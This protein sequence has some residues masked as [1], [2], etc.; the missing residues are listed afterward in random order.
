[1]IQG[2]V[3]Q[4]EVVSEIVPLDVQLAVHVDAVGGCP[5]R[6]RELDEVKQSIGR[7]QLQ[8]HDTCRLAIDDSTRGCYER[9]AMETNCPCA[10]LNGNDCIT[11]L[12][13]VRDG[14][15]LF[16][17]VVPDRETLRS[18]IDDLRAVGTTVSL[19]RI[20]TNVADGDPSNDGVALTEKQREALALAIEEGYYDR[21]RGAT[22]ED[23]AAKL[24]VTPSA[25]SQ[26]L[27]GVERKLVS[28]RARE[29]D[30]R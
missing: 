24:E 21:P 16:S 20:R 23:L 26:R 4:N 19:E 8:D 30:M 14:K 22:L 11:E 25:V 28:E 3:E 18:I 7:S 10:I 12:D 2:T 15:L 5:L 17:L 13:S 29:F 27:N 6:G 1:M 9:T